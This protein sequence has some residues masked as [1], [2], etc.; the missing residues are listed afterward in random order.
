M[1][2]TDKKIIVGIVIFAAVIATLYGILSVAT[3]GNAES[4]DRKTIEK[5]RSLTRGVADILV[6]V[7]R[8]GL[9]PDN[10]GDAQKLAEYEARIDAIEDDM[11][12]NRC[13]ETQE[14]WAYGSFKQEMSEYEAYIAELSRS[15]AS[16]DDL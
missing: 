9:D 3:I 10:L 8:D 4:L 16:N 6:Q 11:A 13:V 2:A 15:S 1:D 5:C 7:A 12:E 14:K